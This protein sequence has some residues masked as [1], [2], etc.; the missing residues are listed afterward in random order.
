MDWLDHHRE[1]ERLSFRASD[2]RRENDRDKMSRLLRQAASAEEK[3][4]ETLS[5][6][7]PKTWNATA[8][9]IA[10]LYLQAGDLDV[11]EERALQFLLSEK[12]SGY[13]RIRFRELLEL[14]WA[15]G[16]RVEYQDERGE[17]IVVELGRKNHQSFGI[18]LN[19]LVSSA[20]HVKSSLYRTAELRQ[21]LPFLSSTVRRGMSPKPCNLTVI[22]IDDYGDNY[23]ILIQ[24]PPIQQQPLGEY[25]DLPPLIEDFFNIADAA[26]ESPVNTLSELVPDPAS[27]LQILEAFHALAPGGRTN[28]FVGIRASDDSRGVSLDPDVKKGLLAATKALKEQEQATISQTDIIR[29]TLIGLDLQDGT[30][31]VDSNDGKNLTVRVGKMVVEAYLKQLRDRKVEVYVAEDQGGQLLFRGALLD[32]TEIPPDNDI[33]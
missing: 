9:S 11:A 12:T 17:A 27:R 2:A 32:P 23:S 26:I 25:G 4:I 1:S 8:I 19:Q 18:P 21:A 13:G 31:K 20:E 14:I 6:G 3:A 24:E 15:E 33:S 16:R 28:D 22:G 5:T 10:S 7:Q 29:G 30:I